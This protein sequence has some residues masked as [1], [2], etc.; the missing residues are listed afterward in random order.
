MGLKDKL[1]GWPG[2]PLYYR[3]LIEYG[4]LSRVI[5]KSNESLVK[6]IKSL[7]FNN[8]MQQYNQF[9]ND[10]YEPVTAWLHN[11][12]LHLSMDACRSPKDNIRLAARRGFDAYEASD[13]NNTFTDEEFSEYYAYAKRFGITLLT[14]IERTFFYYVNKALVPFM[15]AKVMFDP[16]YIK[17]EFGFNKPM[18]VIQEENPLAYL[19]E[20]SRDEVV[21]RVIPDYFN[22]IIDWGGL[23][24]FVHPHCVDLLPDIAAKP[25]QE[26]YSS[27]VI[28]RAS[29]N[30]EFKNPLFLGGLMS[31]IFEIIKR[32]SDRDSVLIEDV[33]PSVSGVTLDTKFKSGAVRYQGLGLKGLTPYLILPEQGLPQLFNTLKRVYDD[34]AWNKL[35]LDDFIRQGV[36]KVNGSI[37]NNHFFHF[38]SYTPWVRD[39]LIPC[40]L[41]SVPDARL[42]ANSRV[43]NL[44]E[45]SGCD[46]HGKNRASDV[47]DVLFLP[48]TKG[49]GRGEFIK[50]LEPFSFLDAY[51]EKRSFC[52]IQ[53]IDHKPINR[54]LNNIVRWMALQK[55][56]YLERMLNGQRMISNYYRLSSLP[57]SVRSML[58]SE[59]NISEGVEAVIPGYLVFNAY[60]KL[61][62][63]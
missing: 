5:S 30:G 49:I 36:T 22:K 62:R 40:L 35:S 3:R 25:R 60:I 14:S 7:S 23:C 37:S 31:D 48:K 34:S 26:P 11:H 21:K 13:H 57:V 6:R 32:V 19:D 63:L 16:F 45:T 20:P 61:R 15:E 39:Q 10:D 1:L 4:A 29:V 27:M 18:S 38:T 52:Y 28:Q 9:L 50:G 46:Y 33:N 42:W 44:H 41:D 56:V 59:L 17:R 24:V 58:R 2:V 8:G 51:R 55:G 47:K 53:S 12:H 43:F 54:F